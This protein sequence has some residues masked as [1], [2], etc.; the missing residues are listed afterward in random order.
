MVNTKE[1]VK[2]LT[3]AKR[4]LREVGWCKNYICK[5]RKGEE[6][7]CRSMY[8]N[9]EIIGSYCAVGAIEQAAVNHPDDEDPI[10]SIAFKAIRKNIPVAH[11]SISAW[12]DS[13]NNVD[14][15]I[16]V[17]DKAIVSLEQ[18]Q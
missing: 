6:I 15:V 13:R 12:N 7:S 1:A 10:S 5:G 18:E 11:T 9:P 16:E 4:L 3:E 14:E 2:V 17:F 8:D